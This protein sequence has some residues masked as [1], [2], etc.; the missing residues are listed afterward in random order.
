MGLHIESRASESAHVERVWRARSSDVDRMTAV[1]TGTWDLVV[2][3]HRGLTSAAVQGP[4]TRASR[5]PVPEDAEFCGITFALGTTMPHLPVGG[6][7]DSSADLAAASGRSVWLAGSTWELFDYDDAEFFVRR[8]VREGVLVRDPVVAAALGGRPTGVSERTV[9]RRFAATTGLARGALQRIDRARQAAVLLQ[10]GVAAQRVVHRLGYFD[11]PHLAR[12]LTRFIGRTATSL[13]AP[14]R[15][16]ES[17]E[18]LSL[19]YKTIDPDP[20]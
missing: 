10:E 8:L 14:D 17:T 19:L 9:Q 4:E 16:P 1:A 20:S 12:S 3:R 6:L 7:V 2:W 11:Q 13:A 5:A 15:G 18:P